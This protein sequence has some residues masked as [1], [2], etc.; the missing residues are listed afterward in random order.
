MLQ[1]KPPQCR[2]KFLISDPATLGSSHDRG[3][4]NTLAMLILLAL[5][6]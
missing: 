4:P 2:V 1:Q 5:L 3:E 6:G